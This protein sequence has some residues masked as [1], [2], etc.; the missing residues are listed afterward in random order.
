M[1]TIFYWWAHTRTAVYFPKSCNKLCNAG[2]CRGYPWSSASYGYLLDVLSLTISTWES[3]SRNS[4]GHSGTDTFHLCVHG[5]N[6]TGRGTRNI[7]RT[8]GGSAVHRVEQ[9]PRLGLC[10][11]SSRASQHDAFIRQPIR[12]PDQ[13]YVTSLYHRGIGTY[14]GGYPGE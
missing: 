7:S 3:H 4:Y 5:S 14:T 13:G 10:S 2:H 9:F 11:A 8:M 1:H 6:C 12:L